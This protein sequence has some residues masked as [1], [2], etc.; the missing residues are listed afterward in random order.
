MSDATKAILVGGLAC[1]VLD[2]TQAFI[3]WGL[4]GATPSRILQGIAIG[5][6]GPASLQGGWATAALGAACH[7]L[8]AFGAAAVFYLASRNIAFMTEHPVLAGMLYG[9]LVFWFMQYVV[10]PLSRTHRRPWSDPAL[11][12]TGPIGHM[13]LVGLPIAFAVK[14]LAPLVAPR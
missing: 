5:L 6:L 1:G 11:I 4:E 14:R 12:L 2:I 9:E 13:F 10:I 8:I 3:A 7:F